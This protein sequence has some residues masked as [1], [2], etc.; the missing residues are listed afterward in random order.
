M[1]SARRIARGE[2]L[3]VARNG[4]GSPRGRHYNGRLCL[5]GPPEGGGAAARRGARRSSSLLVASCAAARVAG[6]APT[7]ELHV[8]VPLR[9]GEPR[10]GGGSRAVRRFSRC[11]FSTRGSSRSVTGGSSS[12]RSRR[13]GP[14]PATGSSGR[15]RLRPDVQLHDGTPLGAGRGRRRPRRA[16]LGGGAFGQRADLG[17]PVPGRESPRAGGPARR[18]RP[19]YRSCSRSRTP[20]SWRSSRIRPWVSP[21]RA[22]VAAG[23]GTGPVPG[24][25]AHAR[26]GSSW[27]RRRAG[28]GSRRRAPG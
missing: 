10:S 9:S 14:F 27:R 13:P 22:A 25:R 24:G 28:G 2:G 7:G 6:A 21:S 17:P 23:V 16:G 26:R 8:G 3:P 15:F 19:P 5:P 1:P 4:A 11:G 20:R 12:P 18:G